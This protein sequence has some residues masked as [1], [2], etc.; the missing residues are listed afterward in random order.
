MR[1]F[2]SRKFAVS[3]G[4]SRAR[5]PAGGTTDSAGRRRTRTR[6]HLIASPLRF[7][8]RW[9]A[10]RAR[11]RALAPMHRA[12]Q[13]ASGKRASDGR[14]RRDLAEDESLLSSLS[15]SLCLSQLRL[16]S[17]LF[18]SLSLSIAEKREHNGSRSPFLPWR[19]LRQR[20][21]PKGVE[22][23]WREENAEG[24]NVRSRLIK[25][26]LSSGATPAIRYTLRPSFHLFT[27]QTHFRRWVI[28]GARGPV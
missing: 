19:G 27:G 24:E 7:S 5:V 6:V 22:K 16:L 2:A 1:H 3:R 17:F 9:H 12:C 26:L 8:L 28:N 13:I 14:Y 4:V 20:V 23:M 18:P 11:N 10:D 25:L 21:L 15:L